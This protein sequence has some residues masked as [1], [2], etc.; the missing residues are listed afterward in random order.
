[1]EEKELS[2]VL[3][4]LNIG[5]AR[6]RADLNSSKN[7]ENWENGSMISSDNSVSGKDFE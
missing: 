3:N 4:R 6:R 5:N 7:L 2:G 1:M